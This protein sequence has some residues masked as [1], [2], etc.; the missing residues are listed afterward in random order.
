VGLVAGDSGYSAKVI[1]PARDAESQVGALSGP[2][3]D[4][5]E[6]LRELLGDGA[7]KLTAQALGY[8]L[9]AWQGR[10][11]D[12]YRLTHP[13]RSNGGVRYVLSRAGQ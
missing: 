12:G 13:L 4:L 1:E 6:V 7:A 10:I 5:V 9:R 11:L 2:R 3:A 8:K